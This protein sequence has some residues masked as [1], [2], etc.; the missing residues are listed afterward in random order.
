MCQRYSL[1]HTFECEILPHSVRGGRDFTGSL[2]YRNFVN[3]MHVQRVSKLEANF[4]L[5]PCDRFELESV[6]ESAFR[7]SQVVDWHLQS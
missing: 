4:F 7:S 2:I 1:A 5:G 3:E 6:L